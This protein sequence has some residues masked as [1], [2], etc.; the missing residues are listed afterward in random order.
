M[1]IRATNRIIDP[2]K[3][4]QKALVAKVREYDRKKR[5]KNKRNFENII[6]CVSECTKCNRKMNKV[7]AEQQIASKKYE[8]SEDETIQYVRD[9]APICIPCIMGKPRSQ[10]SYA[11]KH[12][13]SETKKAFRSYIQSKIKKNKR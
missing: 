11:E 9:N 4:F 7:L 12:M 13:H 3:E 5:G 6:I 8:P 10:E 1:S 2:E